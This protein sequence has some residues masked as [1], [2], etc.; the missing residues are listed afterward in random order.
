MSIQDVA[1]VAGVSKSTVSRI[2][3]G[4]P[5]PSAQTVR[6]VLRV[7]DQ[8]GYKPRPLSQRPGV[9]KAG[10][11]RISTGTIG[12]LMLDEGHLRYPQM[13]AEMLC[14]VSSAIADQGMNL[15]FAEVKK[16]DRVPPL[17]KRM[18]VDG[19]LLAGSE[20]DDHVITG[21][22][23][24]PK[25]WLTSHSSLD[26]DQVLLGNEAVG[27]IAAEYFLNQGKSRLVAVKPPSRFSVYAHRVHA[28]RY[29]A[30]MAGAKVTVLGEDYD[31]VLHEHLPERDRMPAFYRMIARQF[32][33]LSPQPEGMFVPSDHFTAELYPIFIEEEINPMTDVMVVSCDHQTNFL[34]GLKPAP[35]TID[36]GIRVIGRRAVE[37]LLW[38]INHPGE[39]RNVQ[40]SVTPMIVEPE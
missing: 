3:N 40:L 21:L 12:L 31:P 5:G 4:Q 29:I 17:V 10:R 16:H 7:M 8:I 37:Q 15:L 19:L 22:Q 2:I 38:R 30:E 28:F 33:S 1:K 35:V 24:L 36:L 14:G 34:T 20:V 25:V 11:E 23:P 9:R 26:N 18:Q 13:F 6:T 39:A 32:K 27:R